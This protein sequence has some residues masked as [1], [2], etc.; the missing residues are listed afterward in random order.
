MN[1]LQ[2]LPTLDI[3]GVETG[4]IDLARYLVKKGHKAIVV[5]DGGK[6][7]REL[8]NI[9]SRHYKLPIGKKSIFNIIRMIGE[10]S[11]II[12][13]E[14]IDIIHARSRVPALIAYFAARSTGRVFITTAHGYY[15]NPVMSAPMGWGKYVIVA[16]NVIARHMTESFNVA[17]ERIRMIP[18]GVDLNIFTPRK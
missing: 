9:G 10:L 6:L 18:R 1:I 13:R 17:R 12:R 14:D 7:V 2:V 15:K 5:S 8:E 3:G 4:T 11:D 16:S